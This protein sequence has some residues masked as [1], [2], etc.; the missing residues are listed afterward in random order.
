MR[1]FPQL[2]FEAHC[3]DWASSMRA[4][5]EAQTRLVGVFLEIDQFDMSQNP[6]VIA[7]LIGDFLDMPADAV[8]RFSQALE[9]D[10]PERTTEQFSEVL[11][12][13]E[14]DWTEDEKTTFVSVCGEEMEEYGYSFTQSYYGSVIEPL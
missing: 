2:A 5:R 13:V 4:W 10:R 6:A 1:K 7:A 11:D 3:A 8:E 12:F 14:L 9:V